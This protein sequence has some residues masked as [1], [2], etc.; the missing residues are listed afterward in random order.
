M[1]TF[2]SVFCVV[3]E[4]VWCFRGP[5][6]AQFC[7]RRHVPAATL[8]TWR[9]C[10]SHEN[11]KDIQICE[12]TMSQREM[13][14]FSNKSFFS[15]HVLMPVIAVFQGTLERQLCDPQILIP[16]LSKPEV[17][18]STA[19]N[20]REIQQ[21]NNE[22]TCFPN[23]KHQ[24][25]SFFKIYQIPPGP[26]TNPCRHVGAGRV[27]GAAQSTSQ[28]W[29]KRLLWI[30]SQS[31][32]SSARSSRTGICSGWNSP[33]LTSFP[34][35]SRCLQDAEFLLKLAEEVN[36]TFRNNVGIFFHFFPP[37]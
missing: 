36:A 32:A 26:A 22:V 37:F 8:C 28:H 18:A 30:S 15:M 21:P 35:F 10:C 23:A 20:T 6:A 31:T 16:D 9:I 12:S 17:R 25:T 27:P 24:K 7:S 5:F 34:L 2:L 29:V 14:H 1:W 19:P 3:F 4:C 13:A 33:V 11:P